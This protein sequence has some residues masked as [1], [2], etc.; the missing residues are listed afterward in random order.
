MKL[1][2]QQT[3]HSQSSRFKNRVVSVSPILVPGPQEVCRLLSWGS[4]HIPFMYLQA[5]VKT[6]YFPLFR[7]K[8]R[9]LLRLFAPYSARLIKRPRDGS[10]SAV[11]TA[12]GRSAMCR[13]LCTWSGPSC[14][15]AACPPALP[16]R[17]CPSR[18]QEHTESSITQKD[19][20]SQSQSAVD[21][22]D[23]LER[24]HVPTALKPG[25]VKPAEAV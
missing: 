6:D 16:L 22:H 11:C 19:L 23:V 20:L 24:F 14:G 17:V 3:A 13:L 1:H 25:G 4:L 2:F 18:T 10:A 5:N 21:V 12:T 7:Q 8:W 9:M 15:R